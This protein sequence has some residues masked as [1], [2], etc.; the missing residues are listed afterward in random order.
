MEAK[1]SKGRPT[2]KPSMT[3]VLEAICAE[4]EAAGRALGFDV[5]DQEWF[6]KTT[7]G[8]PRLRSTIRR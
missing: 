7:S 3:A 5:A 1:A 2:R 4:I 8:K 6:D